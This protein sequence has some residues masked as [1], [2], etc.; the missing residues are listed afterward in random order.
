MVSRSKKGAGK[1]K[2]DERR[3]EMFR[4]FFNNAQVGFLRTTID[5]GR[6]LEANY[7]LAEML[8]YDS[9]KELLTEYIFSEHYLETGARERMVGKALRTGEIKNVEARLTRRD[10]TIIWVRYTGRIYP[11]KGYIEAVI[12]DITEE[13]IAGEALRQSE[14]TARALLNA[15]NEKAALLDRRKNILS[16]NRTWAQSLGRPS[17]ELIGLCADEN[18]F[19]VLGS[20]AKV[21]FEAVL[22]AKM[23][24]RFVNN[25][26]GRV[27][28]NQLYPIFDAEGDVAR[29]ALFSRD[30]TGQKQAEKA[31]HCSNEILF[32]EHMKRK[33]LSRDLINLLEKDRQLVAMELHDQIGQSVTTLKMDLEMILE[34][35]G[36]EKTPL[37]IRTES[38]MEKALHTIRDIKEIA[39][40]LRPR[41]LDDLG[42]VPAVNELCDAMRRRGSVN[43][44]FFTKNIPKMIDPESEL[45]VYRITQEA[46]NNVMKHSGADEVFV[47]LIRKDNYILTS[48]EDNGNGFELEEDK[49]AGADGKKTLGLLIMEE[50]AVQLSGRFS[51]ESSLGKGTHL[52]AEIPV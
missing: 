51:V 31:L 8:G 41:L 12:V 1:R 48:V 32:K 30:I 15:T 29:V 23:S 45:A 40:G 46:L 36:I 13:K 28:D 33:Q 11:D 50:R 16:I 47:N 18:L 19:P 35:I 52:W 44:R 14:E 10:N 39:A 17:E 22:T 24:S 4:N 38:A 20:S 42:L 6:I 3:E 43:V 9:R 27:F 49:G 26:D 34:D 25:N 21:M 5:H 7:R 37:R 2:T